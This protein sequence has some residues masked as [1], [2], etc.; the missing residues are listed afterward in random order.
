MR[1]FCKIL[2][3]I[4]FVFLPNLFFAQNVTVS[5]RIDSL[6][7]WIGQQTQ[8]TFEISQPEGKRV[9]APFF[10]DE[11]V[12]GLEIVELPQSD[13]TKQDGYLLVKQSYT[14]T[15]FDDTLYYIPPFPFVDEKDTFWSNSLSL[16]VIQPFEIDTVSNQIADIKTVYTPP[17]NWKKLIFTI[18][19]I[20]LILSILGVIVI[21]IIY[22]L[23][24]KKPVEVVKYE[25][26]IS[27][28]DFAIGRL[29]EIKNSKMWQ[30]NRAKEYHT[31]LTDVIREYIDRNYKIA[32]LEMTSEEI[33]ES[34]IFLSK[35]NK[36]AYNALRQMLTLAD[37]AKFAKWNP[38]PNEHE[39]SLTNAF[40]FVKET[41][42]VVEEKEEKIELKNDI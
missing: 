15:S 2:L 19:L 11:I 27:P 21:F 1:E 4:V 17:F 32:C 10:S 40:F 24:K 22:K 38:T 12:S 25:T 16:K 14:L 5:A 37:L 13:T 8:I 36:P 9:N 42:V 39:Q 26:K 31:E 35:E 6:S 33:F 41:T 28:Y 23:K 34:M 7:I 29:E 30:Q 3:L 20:F 18:L